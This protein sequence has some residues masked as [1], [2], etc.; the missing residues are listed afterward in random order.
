MQQILLLASPPHHCSD[1]SLGLLFT[2]LC[3]SLSVRCCFCIPFKVVAV[4]II[5]A[6]IDKIFKDLPN[7]FSNVDDFF[8]L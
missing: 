5:L 3:Q 6:K 2:Y 4:S 8:L 7:V 1:I